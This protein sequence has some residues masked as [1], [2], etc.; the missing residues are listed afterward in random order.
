VKC[1]LLEKREQTNK[2]QHLWQGLTDTTIFWAG[3][4]KMGLGC[5][6]QFGSGQRAVGRKAPLPTAHCRP[7]P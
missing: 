7:P 2:A 1:A 3:N 5:L 4:P 6:L